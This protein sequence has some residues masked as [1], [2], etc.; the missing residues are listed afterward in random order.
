MIEQT[1]LP[2]D[3][4]PSADSNSLKFDR[5]PVFASKLVVNNYERRNHHSVAKLLWDRVECVTQQQSL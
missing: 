1:R 4:R 5:G 2:Q 3:L